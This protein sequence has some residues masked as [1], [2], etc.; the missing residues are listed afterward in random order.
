MFIHILPK[1]P[2]GNHTTPDLKYHTKT[3]LRAVHYFAG[4]GNTDQHTSD[5]RRGVNLATY[6]LPSP[7][8][9]RAAVRG[10]WGRCWPKGCPSS[11][12]S[13]EA[14]KHLEEGRLH[15]ATCDSRPVPSPL[16]AATPNPTFPAPLCLRNLGTESLP[17]QVPLSGGNASLQ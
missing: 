13:P 2:L 11:E 8:A 17:R 9:E 3:K 12:S 7:C 15:S 10:F 14:N 4:C 5:S 1:P 16:S 6:G